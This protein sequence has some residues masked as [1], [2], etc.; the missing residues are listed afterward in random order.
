MKTFQNL[1]A[2]ALIAVAA[3]AVS[4]KPEEI[5]ATSISTQKEAT[6][7]VDSTLQLTAVI[8]PE[9][10]TMA[11]QWKS[12]NMNIATVDEKG[13]VKAVSDGECNIIASVGTLEAATKLTVYNNPVTLELAQVGVTPTTCTVSIT[14]SDEEGYYY[15]GYATAELASTTSDAE[16]AEL[17]LTNLNKMIQQYAAYGY[18]KTLKDLLFKGKKELSAAGLTA[19]TDYVMFAFGIDVENEKPS[20]KMTRLPFKTADVV[21]SDMTIE[22]KFDSIS[23]KTSSTSVD[24]C[25]HISITPSVKT[26]AYLFQGTKKSIL[27][28]TYDNSPIKFLEAAVSYYGSKISSYLDK[29]DKSVYYKNLADGETFVFAAAGYDGGFTTKAFTLEYVYNAPKD[30]KPARLVQKI[31]PAAQEV[32]VVEFSPELMIPG[33]CH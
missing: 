25:V 11:V 24:T 8:Q 4:C 13:L 3:C 20:P 15:C 29:G 33:M 17:V 2:I 30:G 18:N 14:P 6:L 19:T 23:Y 5:P 22:I 1:A 26:E 12:S 9:N 21:P 7:Y 31:N 16:L 27:E 28:K 32:G 10:T